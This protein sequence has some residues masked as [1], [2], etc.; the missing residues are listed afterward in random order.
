MQ[1]QNFTNKMYESA[2]R[3]IEDD[4]SFFINEA[5]EK[6]DMNAIIS[7]ANIKYIRALA[8]PEYHDAAK[9]YFKNMLLL[10]STQYVKDG[11]YDFINQATICFESYQDASDFLICCKLFI[12][13]SSDYELIV[14]KGIYTFIFNSDRIDGEFTC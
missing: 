10:T 5:T 4:R 6:A 1:K 9:V 2:F 12:K 8:S 7:I 11:D 13:Y 3:K 14:D